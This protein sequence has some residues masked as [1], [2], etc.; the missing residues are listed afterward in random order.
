MEPLVQAW[1]AERRGTH[2]STERTN[3]RRVG[4]RRS[5]SEGRVPLAR[6]TRRT[7]VL[8]AVEVPRPR[9]P[10]VPPPLPWSRASRALGAAD[11]PP[12]ERPSERP[13]LKTL[14]PACVDDSHNH[15][16]EL[17]AS[18]LASEPCLDSCIELDAVATPRRSPW[19]LH[20]ALAS[21]ALM[22]V[23]A[24]FAAGVPA[25]LTE[26]VTGVSDGLAGP[27]PAPREI[28]S[29][30]TPLAIRVAIGA[31]APAAGVCAAAGSTT[32][33]ARRARLASGLDV[34]ALAGGFGVAFA[35]SGGEALGVRL[36]GTPLRIAERLRVRTGGPVRHATA[37]SGGGRSDD[38]GIDLRIDS[39]DAR[40]VVPDGDAPVVRLAVVGAW[41]QAIAAGS[42]RTLWA[43][44]GRAAPP[45]KAS[46]TKARGNGGAAGG[47]ALRTHDG[48]VRIGGRTS[49][50]AP[51]GRV[52]PTDLRAAARSDGG[53]VI[54][55]RQSSALW[56]GMLDAKLTP[57]GPLIALARPSARLGMPSVAPSNQGAAV[58]W[59][60]RSVGGHEWMIMVASFGEHGEHGGQAPTSKPIGAGMS[61]S[62]AMLPDGEL[63]LAYAVG[64]PGSHRVVVRRL[65]RDLEPRGEPVFVSPAELNAGQPSAAVG[66]DGGALVAF[67]AAGLGHP[68]RVLAT[69]L[70]C[71]LGRR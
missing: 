18:A 39:D 68:P 7:L 16:I 33:V 15:V 32:V 4:E 24:A 26:R 20:A 13:T 2:V 28:A 62:L 21:A 5:R 53:A 71:D 52:Q 66:A 44:P 35:A 41:V 60:E 47:A 54:A 56:L 48:F 61:P 59:A 69:P 22:M 9:R 30:R 63:L 10:A 12:S 49:H 6:P 36:H 51:A 29:Q 17:S 19:R 23:S 14:P 45:T 46:A 38:D 1:R 3:E 64:A 50:A 11:D 43:V 58:A 40:S 67:F 37:T 34:N 31:A 65:G 8:P 57:N 25:F 70:A 55:L 42:R 27:A